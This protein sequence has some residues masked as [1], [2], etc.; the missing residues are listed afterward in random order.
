[1]PIE[2]NPII[3]GQELITEFLTAI[4]NDL[5]QYMQTENR[6]AS[7]RSAAS[8][9]V[10]ATQTGGQLIG[11]QYIEF[12]FRGR[13]PGKFPPLS[14]IIDW[15]NFRGLPRGMAWIIGK[16]I[17]EAGTKLFQEGRN[18]LNEVITEERIK[19]FTDRLL[20][21]YTAKIKSD[22]ETLIAA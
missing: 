21:T 6:N 3:L 16:R 12:V 5:I 4:K 2:L 1:M 18:V 10:N 8:L 14:A 20:E 11:A 19:E 9:Q 17:S 7:G 15:L 13:G 22:I